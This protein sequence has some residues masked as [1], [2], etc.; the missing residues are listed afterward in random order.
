[1]SQLLPPSQHSLQGTLKD[2]HG[3]RDVDRGSNPADT[4]T[5]NTVGHMTLPTGW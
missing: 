5:E 1:M 2:I 4:V 3:E